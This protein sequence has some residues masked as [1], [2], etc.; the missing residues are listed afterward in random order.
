MNIVKK[1]KKN[2]VKI[3]FLLLFFFYIYFIIVFFFMCFNIVVLYGTGRHILQTSI[4]K[5]GVYTCEFCGKKYSWQS[6]LCR[7]LRETHRA[8]NHLTTRHKLS[9]ISK[10]LSD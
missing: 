7:H 8:S 1:E 6:S 4:G 9:K 3:I 2:F 5:D 10:L